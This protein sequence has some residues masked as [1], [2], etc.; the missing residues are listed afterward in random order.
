MN[1]DSIIRS[2]RQAFSNRKIIGSLKCAD[3]FSNLARSFVAL[4]DSDQLN[5]IPALMI[6]VLENE[7]LRSVNHQADMIIYSLMPQPEG[8]SSLIDS[9]NKDEVNITLEWLGYVERFPFA[10]LCSDELRIVTELFNHTLP[11]K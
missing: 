6:S 2:I 4:R 7:D 1:Y 10:E 3:D 5:V 9:M 11:D 8:W